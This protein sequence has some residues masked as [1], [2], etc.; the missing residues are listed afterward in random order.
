MARPGGL[1]P[2]TIGFVGRYSIRLS[3]GRK[4]SEEF[5]QLEYIP[6]SVGLQAQAPRT[7]D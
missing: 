6:R 7:A 1:E 3:Y 5:A 2:P 4:T